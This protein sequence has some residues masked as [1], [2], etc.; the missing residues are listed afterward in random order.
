MFENADFQ[1]NGGQK[2]ALVGR[3][4]VG[5]ST[6][7]KMLIGHEDADDG[8]IIRLPDLHV[9]HISQDLLHESQ[10]NTLEYEIH[11]ATPELH[12][13]MEQWK[14]QSHDPDVL[15]KIEELNGFKVYELQLEILKYF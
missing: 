2:I 13:L 1:I 8:D 11:Q 15:Q 4:G 6:F 5:K 10:D 3:N 14:Q 12:I 7:L 9:G